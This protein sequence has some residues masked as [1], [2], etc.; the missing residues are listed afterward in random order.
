LKITDVAQ[1]FRLLFPE[2]ASY[3]LVLTKKVLA[4]FWAMFSQTHLVTLFE[5]PT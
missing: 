3:V 5:K 1:I 2:S 4:T